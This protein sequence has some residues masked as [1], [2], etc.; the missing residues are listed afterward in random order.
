MPSTNF[1]YAFFVVLGSSLVSVLIC[2]GYISINIRVT[3]I[4]KSLGGWHSLEFGSLCQCTMIMLS[5][6]M[7]I[8]TLPYDKTMIYFHIVLKASF[9]P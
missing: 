5:L 2:L 6:V 1:T 7:M 4:E 3:S 8:T 9:S